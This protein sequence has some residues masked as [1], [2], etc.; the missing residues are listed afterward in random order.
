MKLS[1]L[2]Y[3]IQTKA[4]KRNCSPHSSSVRQGQAAGG[5]WR[6]TTKWGH[7][8]LTRALELGPPHWA[9][10]SHNTHITHVEVYLQRRYELTYIAQMNYL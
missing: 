10:L 5:Q 4:G 6:V 7:L 2:A 3:T 1:S 8:P 9:I